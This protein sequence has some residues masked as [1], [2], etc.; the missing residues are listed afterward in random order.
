MYFNACNVDTH[1][2]A[3]KTKTKLPLK[4]AY[5]FDDKQE[6]P[7]RYDHANKQYNKYERFEMANDLWT[8]D[9]RM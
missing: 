9:G 8:D 2:F 5:L 3:K 4:F 6:N 7:G 1:A